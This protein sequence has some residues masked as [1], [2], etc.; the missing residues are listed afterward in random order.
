MINAK[1]AKR[2]AFAEEYEGD[3]YQENAQLKFMLAKSIEPEEIRHKLQKARVVQQEIIMHTEGQSTYLDQETYAAL[4]P[5]VFRREHEKGYKK[6]PKEKVEQVVET[7]SLQKMLQQRLREERKKIYV[8]VRKGAGQVSYM[9]FFRP[10]K[11]IQH[12]PEQISQS[13]MTAYHKRLIE[14]EGKNRLINGIQTSM[15]SKMNTQ[16]KGLEI[17]EKL[18]KSLGISLQN[19][20]ILK[21][22]KV[23]SPKELDQQEE[24]SE[25]KKEY[26]YY[27]RRG[28]QL[29]SSEEDELEENRNKNQLVRSYEDLTPQ[30]LMQ[31]QQLYKLKN[32]MKQKEEKQ[33]QQPIKAPEL[34]EMRGLDYD[35]NLDKIKKEIRE[36]EHKNKS[37]NQGLDNQPIFPFIGHANKTV[38]I[39]PSPNASLHKSKLKSGNNSIMIFDQNQTTEMRQTQRSTQANSLFNTQYLDASAS[40][41]Q[42]TMQNTQSKTMFQLNTLNT[43]SLNNT[44]QQTQTNKNDLSTSINGTHQNSKPS[45]MLS[46]F[47]SQSKPSNTMDSLSD[48]KS[49]MPQIRLKSL[50]KTHEDYEREKEQRFKKEGYVGMMMMPEQKDFFINQNKGG[51][52]NYRIGNSYD[53]EVVILKPQIDASDKEIFKRNGMASAAEQLK[54]LVNTKERLIQQDTTFMP[55]RFGQISDPKAF[56]EK[57]VKNNTKI[58]GDEDDQDLIIRRQVDTLFQKLGPKLLYNTDNINNMKMNVKLR[59]YFG[60]LKKISK[61]SMEEREK[62]I[63]RYLFDRIKASDNQEPIL[64]EISE[65]KESEDEDEEAKK[66]ALEIKQLL[67]EEEKLQVMVVIQPKM[68]NKP[69]PKI[70]MIE[71]KQER[72]RFIPPPQILWKNP[73]DFEDKSKKYEIDSEDSDFKDSIIDTKKLAQKQGFNLKI[74]SEK[75]Q[76]AEIEQRRLKAESRQKRLEKTKEKKTKIVKLVQESNIELILKEREERENRLIKKMQKKLEKEKKLQKYDIDSEGDDSSY[77]DDFSDEQLNIEELKQRDELL[78]KIEE[79]RQQE[80]DE[81]QKQMEN[82]HMLKKGNTFNRGQTKWRMDQDLQQGQINPQFIFSPVTIQIDS[83]LIGPTKQSNES[84]A[85]S[86]PSQIKQGSFIKIESASVL[87][88][89]KKSKLEKESEQI[90]QMIQ[91]ENIVIERVRSILESNLKNSVGPGLSK[92]LASLVESQDK[93]SNQTYIDGM[94][95][96]EYKRQLARFKKKVQ[97]MDDLF[98]SKNGVKVKPERRKKP[99]DQRLITKDMTEFE[100]FEEHKR[101]MKDLGLFDVEREIMKYKIHLNREF[102]HDLDNPVNDVEAEVNEHIKQEMQRRQKEQRRYHFDFKPVIIKKLPLIDDMKFSNMQIKSLAEKKR[103]WQG[104]KK[105]TYKPSDI[106]KWFK[107][108][109]ETKLFEIRNMLGKE[110]DNEYRFLE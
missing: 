40:K 5:G 17:F 69:E 11:P 30:K 99:R 29:S 36:I 79:T 71:K 32:L 26:K 52:K 38:S 76:F 101:K 95:N 68:R 105:G 43:I 106:L 86:N 100:K 96:L 4:V 104:S 16:Q 58:D 51:N 81:Q 55:S 45:M 47:K 109:E 19:K 75:E 91:N 82:S 56:T 67:E 110:Q 84:I 57:I 41:G 87:K 92:S 70:K 1:T 103:I 14:N 77:D 24:K 6:P 107:V 35:K 23:T 93:T 60:D 34:Y 59:E 62:I 50:K 37:R 85:N 53:N 8:D 73:M 33:K 108:Y 72:K 9:K 7:S 89:K 10:P 80:L 49:K 25:E 74:L 13:T 66:K 90:D 3:N 27:G 44:L 97:N 88:K 28:E 46:M 64:E 78:R 63:K 21:K 20:N 65:K 18:S 94:M 102:F 39:S 54:S 15:K 2:V 61:L 31:I 22:E 42:T 83:D 12:N 48:I 98:I